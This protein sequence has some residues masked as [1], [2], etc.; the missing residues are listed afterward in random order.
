MNGVTSYTLRD[1]GGSDPITLLVTDESQN[2]DRH[3]KSAAVPHDVLDVTTTV[4]S[5][6]ALRVLL[7][8]DAPPGTQAQAPEA[9]TGW[10]DRFGNLWHYSR[11]KLRHAS[12][13]PFGWLVGVDRGAPFSFEQDRVLIYSIRVKS[14][15]DWNRHNLMK[16]FVTGASGF[17]GA[18]LVHELVA[19]G[20][21]VRALLRPKPDL[22]GLQG[23]DFEAVSGALTDTRRLTDLMKGF[24]WCF[25]AAAS[26]HLWLRDY[27]PM[28]AANV[29]GT[30]SVLRAAA[31]AGCA[32]IVYTSTVGC[33]GLPV[34]GNGSTVPSTEETPI[35]R[36]QL[37]NHYK[38]SKWE[39]EQVA[40]GLAREGA[41]IVVVNPTAPLGPRDVKPTPTG[42][43]IVDFL[44]EKL[45][46]YL[47]TG[48]NWVHVRDVAIGHILAAEKGRVGERYILGN[49]SG[50][51]TLR[52]ALGALESITGIAAPK[53]RLPYWVALAAAHVE[54]TISSITLKPPR[55]VLAG[56]KMAR[57]K[58]YFSPEKAIQEL[59]LPQSDPR[60]AMAEAVAWFSEHG[61]VGKR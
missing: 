18:N 14:G 44:N 28:Y 45:P 4:T 25:H 21:Q 22:R 55:A 46:A 61:Y 40:L 5:L 32:R 8:K 41:P 13:L 26:Y 52:D 50:N 36:D 58:M 6:Q 2:L 31:A 20:H 49:A 43:I 9:G 39:A 59:G 3:G 57:H 30:R 54:E 27:R 16:C 37:S 12:P 38:L 10:P 60:Q 42:K 1:P 48:L 17:V 33:I 23:T 29:D 15:T 47:D 34:N 53:L 19:R 51:W 35:T 7:L 24:D 56:V 11:R